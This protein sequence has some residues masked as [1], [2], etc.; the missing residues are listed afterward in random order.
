MLLSIIVPTRNRAELLLRCLL[1]LK[2]QT[3]AGMEVLVVDDGSDAMHRASLV[4]AWPQ[5]DERFRLIEIAPGGSALSSGPS[6]VRNRGLTE[7]RGDLI[8]F[9]DDDDQWVDPQHAS[10][11]VQVFDK[12][13]ELD[14]LLGNQ[15]ALHVDGRCVEDWLP[16]LSGLCAQRTATSDGWYRVSAHDLCQSGGFGHMNMLVL[17]RP[18]IDAMGG[19][20]WTRVSYEEDRDFFWRA[21]DAARAMVFSPRVVAQHHVPDPAR[22]VNVS[23]SFSQ[24]ERWLVANMVSQHIVAS[25]RDPDIVKLNMQYQGDLFRR[26]ASAARADNRPAAAARLAWQALSCRFSWKWLAMCCLYSLRARSGD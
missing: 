3:H 1:A 21:V 14:L 2:D 18:L 4:A 26:L 7:A 17:R 23:T 22:R 6:A 16:G 9:C 24:Q 8:A 12:N 20:F 13:T 5:L 11:A 19:G 25:V 15:R 10:R